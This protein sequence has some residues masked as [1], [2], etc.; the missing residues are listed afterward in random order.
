M[1]KL[2]V[3]I[4]LFIQMNAFSQNCDS[5]RIVE[6]KEKAWTLLAGGIYLHG[7]SCILLSKTFSHR[8]P[9][10]YTN[11]AAVQIDILGIYFLVKERRKERKLNKHYKIFAE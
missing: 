9:Y 11:I 10:V 3:L 7:I 2:V 5:A 8:E 4:F 6:N 1:N